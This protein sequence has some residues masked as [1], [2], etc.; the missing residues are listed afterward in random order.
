MP[1]ITPRVGREKNPAAL[2]A[3]GQ[4]ERLA[5]SRVLESTDVQTLNPRV[6]RVTF[7]GTRRSEPP[8]PRR[9]ACSS[10]PALSRGSPGV[11]PRLSAHGGQCKLPPAGSR[12]ARRGGSRERRPMA[13]R[14]LPAPPPARLTR[15]LPCPSRTS[16]RPSRFFSSPWPSRPDLLQCTLPRS[17]FFTV[18]IRSA[19]IL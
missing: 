8:L 2:V 7:L 1:E 19:I 11:A 15:L 18:Q 3:A 9:R 5:A 14:P 10:T 6:L 17:S 13:F 12:R 4:G 16:L